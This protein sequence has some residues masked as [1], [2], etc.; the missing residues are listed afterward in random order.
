M[1]M[2]YKLLLVLF[3]LSLLPPGYFFYKQYQ[4]NELIE[5][6]LREHNFIG[7]ERNKENAFLIS[8][9]LRKDFNVEQS[10]FKHLTF[11]NRPF[12]RE[13]TLELL[14]YKEGL[15]GEGTRVL[16]NLYN[17]LGYD[18]TRLTLYNRNL[19]GS[20]TLISIV[21]N[22]NEYFVDSINSMDEVNAILKKYDINASSFNL[23]AYIDDLATRKKIAKQKKINKNTDEIAYFLDKYW[24]Y[25]YEAT[26]YSKLLKKLGIDVRA[27][28]FSRTNRFF[29]DLAEK[30]F[31]INFYAFLVISF[32]IAFFSHALYIRDKIRYRRYA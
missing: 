32:M 12:L 30:P 10:T 17:Y 14:Q 3:V 18:A 25:S 8:D 26:P 15:C 11:K 5:S 7:L 21:D 4:E 13:P 29:S 23:M 31:M 2:K 1:H 6:Y 27:F 22:G 19:H 9:Q 24:L 28:N 20:H 16:V